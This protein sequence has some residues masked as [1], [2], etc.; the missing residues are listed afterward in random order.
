MLTTALVFSFRDAMSDGLGS[1]KT[2][3]SNGLRAIEDV[4]ASEGVLVRPTGPPVVLSPANWNPFWSEEM[5]D[6]A[7]LRAIRPADL[8]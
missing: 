6:E 1:E 7:I 4:P 2:P 5:R 8:P 3:E